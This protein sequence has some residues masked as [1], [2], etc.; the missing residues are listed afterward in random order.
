MSHVILVSIKS[1]AE[2]MD[3]FVWIKYVYTLSYE[4]FING[5]LLNPILPEADVSSCWSAVIGSVSL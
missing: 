4:A 3:Y 2:K 5:V 1:Y